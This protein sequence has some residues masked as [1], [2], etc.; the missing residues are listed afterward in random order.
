MAHELSLR[1]F[2]LR[3]ELTQ[4]SHAYSMIMANGVPRPPRIL[5][6]QAQPVVLLTHETQL[7]RPAGQPVRVGVGRVTV[8]RTYCVQSRHVPYSM[9]SVLCSTRARRS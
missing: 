9:L 1:S 7:C 6:S 5:R 8:L 2:F 4:L 3:T